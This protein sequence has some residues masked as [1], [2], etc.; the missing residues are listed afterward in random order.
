MSLLHPTEREPTKRSQ[1]LYIYI[2]IEYIETLKTQKQDP[3]SIFLAHNIMSSSPSWVYKFP[4]WVPIGIIS[5][6]DSI[7]HSILIRYDELNGLP[8]FNFVFISHT[9]Q[10]PCLAWFVIFNFFFFFCAGV[11]PGETPHCLAGA[12]TAL[13]TRDSSSCC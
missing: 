5:A 3:F 1:S 10:Y 2:Y 12:I 7:S 9:R 13:K 11:S 8:L 4:S 6:V